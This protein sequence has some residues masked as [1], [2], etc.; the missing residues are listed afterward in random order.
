[1]TELRF[2]EMLQ[3]VLREYYLPTLEKWVANVNN[4]PYHDGKETVEGLIEG[5]Q[6][7]YTLETEGWA[8]HVNM[9]R[10]SVYTHTCVR[11]GMPVSSHCTW[12]GRTVPTVKVK[13]V[14]HPYDGS[15]RI[16]LILWGPKIYLSGYGRFEG[17][18]IAQ[19]LRDLYK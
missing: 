15:T 2:K 9:N 13:D 19:K 6:V 14:E 18:E 10:H 12:D 8:P 17:L 11:Q 3:E 16:S 5:L 7:S 4:N 1:M